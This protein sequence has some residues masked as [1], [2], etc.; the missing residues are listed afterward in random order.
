MVVV[1]AAVQPTVTWLTIYATLYKIIDTLH[2]VTPVVR[3]RP[4]HR[5]MILPPDRLCLLP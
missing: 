1:V 3:S 2:T 4:R 5:L